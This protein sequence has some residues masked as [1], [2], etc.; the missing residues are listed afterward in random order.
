MTQ[1]EARNI[2]PFTVLYG[3]G[4]EYVQV[5]KRI[6]DGYIAMN[7]DTTHYVHNMIFISFE[8]MVVFNYE[9]TDNSWETSLFDEDKIR[10]LNDFGFCEH[11]E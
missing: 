3:N 1:E 5:L 7:Y 11:M 6:S 4:D 8:D 2:E 10:H 9:K